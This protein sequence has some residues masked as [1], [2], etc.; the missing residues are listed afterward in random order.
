MDKIEVGSVVFLKSGGPYMTV[1]KLS[2][3]G[4]TCN[5]FDGPDLYEGIFNIGTLKLKTNWG[6]KWYRRNKPFEFDEKPTSTKERRKVM[7]WASKPTS[8]KEVYEDYKRN[9]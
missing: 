7:G 4:Y 9:Y 3:K 2:R 8:P 1:S 5:W 6:M